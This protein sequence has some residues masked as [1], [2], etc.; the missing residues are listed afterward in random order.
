L[1][2][3]EGEREKKV[4]LIYER[5]LTF[6]AKANEPFLFPFDPQKIAV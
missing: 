6:F 1:K 3:R 5:S 4:S 2:E